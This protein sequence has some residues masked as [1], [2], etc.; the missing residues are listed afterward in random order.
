[1]Y[2]CM[3]ASTLCMYLCTHEK[4]NLHMHICFHVYLIS[5]IYLYTHV[6]VYIRQ[7]EGET[8]GRGPGGGGRREKVRGERE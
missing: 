6:C 1:M 4:Y 3:Y 7:Q 2:A 8:E 5:C